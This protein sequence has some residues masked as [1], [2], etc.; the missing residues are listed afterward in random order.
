MKLEQYFVMLSSVFVVGQ[1]IK[2]FQCN[3]GEVPECMD[4]SSNDTDSPFYKECQG[5]YEG[6]KPFCRKIFS[7]ILYAETAK[8]VR[9]CGWI[10]EV[11][12]TIDFCKKADTDFI[13][14]MSCLCFSDG[15]NS[16]YHITPS[17][18]LIVTALLIRFYIFK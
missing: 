9:T 11:N 10:K 3:S 6:N 1:A 8:V 2:C 14:Q 5:N 16:S 7:T 17:S 13:T 15:C 4:L 12:E 18:L